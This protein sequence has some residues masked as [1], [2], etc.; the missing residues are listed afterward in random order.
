VVH[1]DPGDVW[2]RERAFGYGGH[3]DSPGSGRP[4]RSIARPP[5][6]K[7]NRTVPKVEPPRLGLNFSAK[8]TVDELFRARVFVEPLVP[9][10][11]EPTAVEMP[12]WRPLCWATPNAAARMIFP[13]SPLFFAPTRNRLGTPPC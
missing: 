3:P 4:A 1:F 11:F 13:V 7:V 12:R 9:V 6:V 10:E 8:P 2:F 5:P